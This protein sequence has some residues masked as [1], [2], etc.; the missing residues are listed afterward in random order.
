M[1]T[2]FQKIWNKNIDYVISYL[3]GVLQVKGKDATTRDAEFLLAIAKTK[4]GMQS[5]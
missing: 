1:N 5:C 3:R 2:H 4:K